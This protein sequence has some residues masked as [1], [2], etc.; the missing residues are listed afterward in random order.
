MPAEVLMRKVKGAVMQKNKP[1]E[2]KTFSSITRFLAA[3]LL[4]DGNVALWANGNDE[5]DWQKSE[6]DA[7]ESL[8]ELPFWNQDIAAGFANHVTGPYKTYAVEVKSITVEMIALVLDLPHPVTANEV[9]IYGLQWQGEKHA[10]MLETN[11]FEHAQESRV[12]KRKRLMPPEFW[13]IDGP[14]RPAPPGEE[15]EHM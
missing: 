7:F 14:D 8:E 1:V 6:R 4:D 11:D 13:A 10:L 9:I 12:K 2:D 15:D 3:E 5:H